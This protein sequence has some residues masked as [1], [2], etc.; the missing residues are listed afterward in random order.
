MRN[1]LMGCVVI[2]TAVGTTPGKGA[3]QPPTAGAGRESP[4]ELTV[5]LG[6]FWGSSAWGCRPPFRD[7]NSVGRAGHHLGCRV[8]LV[9]E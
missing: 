7:Y 8:T 2:L 4:K 9:E 6:G 5:D 1:L 3:E